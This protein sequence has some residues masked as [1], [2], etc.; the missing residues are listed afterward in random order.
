MRRVLYFAA[1]AVGVVLALL[2]EEPLWFVAVAAVLAFP[3]ATGLA[4]QERAGRGAPL[5][6]ALLGALAGG[7]LGALA[8]RLAIAAPDWRSPTC[9]D[10]GG[11]STGT[12]QL[13][14][15]AAAVIFVISAL[16]LGA[17]LA[18][19]GARLTARAGDATERLQAPLSAYPVAVAASSLALIGAGFVTTC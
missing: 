9:A 13:V 4:L 7:V 19:L 5:G 11:T 10:S 16:P 12:Q 1:I 18:A 8:L 3:V 14:L 15:W 17:T 2:G 6:L